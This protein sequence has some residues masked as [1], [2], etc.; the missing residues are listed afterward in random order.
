MEEIWQIAMFGNH[1]LKNI[2]KMMWSEEQAQSE[3]W[4]CNIKDLNIHTFIV[5]ILII[6]EFHG[7]DLI[8]RQPK[9][10]HM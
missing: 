8:I 3:Q 10:S 7:N 5:V 6:V 9:F 4:N 2:H 1:Q